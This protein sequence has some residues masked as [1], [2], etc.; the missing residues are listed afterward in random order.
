MPFTLSA[1]RSVVANVIVPRTGKPVAIVVVVEVEVEVVVVVV[2]DVVVDVVVV[3]VDVVVVV[4]VVVDVVV[5]V[6]EVV[7]VEVVLVVVVV[8]VVVVVVVVD[9]VVVEVLVVDV[10]VEVVLVVEVVVDVVQPGTLTK[11]ATL[12][13]HS[14]S[15]SGHAMYSTSFIKMRQPLPGLRLLLSALY[16]KAAHVLLTSQRCR[17][18]CTVLADLCH[19]P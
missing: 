4:V 16:S 10:V 15:F 2:V 14:Q 12:F 13:S 17:H 8:E 6:V 9:V 18:S 5:V 19:R 11:Q 3:V 7:V 1:L